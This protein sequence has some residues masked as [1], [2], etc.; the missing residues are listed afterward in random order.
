MD[1]VS[2]PLGKGMLSAACFFTESGPS[3][4]PLPSQFPKFFPLASLYMIMCLF[5]S[6]H[7]LFFCVYIPPTC[8]FPLILHLLSFFLPAS[9]CASF[10]LTSPS[11]LPPIILPLFSSAS[12][13]LL[14]HYFPIMRTPPS[15]SDPSPM[16]LP[17]TLPTLSFP[18]YLPHSSLPPLLNLALLSSL[19][20][21]LF[22][23]FYPFPQLQK[24]WKTG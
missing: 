1:S 17:P 18:S 8:S 16:C 22:F 12:S 9:M 11:S 19:I 13:S 4:P 2:T 15:H 14:A 23:L 10:H 21:S 6:F 7:I 5:P 3:L 20:S 24:M